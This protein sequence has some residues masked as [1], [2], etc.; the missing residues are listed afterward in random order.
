MFFDR[1]DA[2]RQLAQLLRGYEGR[3]DVVVLGLPRGGVPVAFEVAEAL[4]TPLDVFVVR[5]LG[6]PWHEELAMG[7]IASGGVRVM[8]DDIVRH[9]RVSPDDIERVAAREEAE[10]QRRELAYRGGRPP[11][12]LTGKAALIV[13]DGLATGASMRAAVLAVKAHAPKEVVVA[14]PVG[15]VEACATLRSEADDVVCALSPREFHAV[16]LHYA[17][18]SQTEDGE[19]VELMSRAKRP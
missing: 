3:E 17:R 11:L 19:V 6:L 8:N 16:G 9:F 4:G 14:V 2:G 12:E 15:S 10:L 18:F 5:K 13:D 1:E 7:A